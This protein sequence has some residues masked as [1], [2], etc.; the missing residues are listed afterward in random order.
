MQFFPSETRDRSVSLRRHYKQAPIVARGDHTDSI[1]HNS[2]ICSY[3]SWNTMVPSIARPSTA[4]VDEKK[5]TYKS[6]L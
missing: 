1:P 5:T 4:N 6:E 2:K 3:S